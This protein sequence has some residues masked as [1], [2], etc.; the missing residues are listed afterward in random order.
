[1]KPN[2][3]GVWEWFDENGTKRLMD[4]VDVGTAEHPWFRVYWWGGYYDVYDNPEEPEKSPFR[5]AEW[6]D[7]WGKFVGEEGSVEE[8]KLYHMPD[9]KKLQKIHKLRR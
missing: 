3:P 2:K 1:M 7:R 5:Y 4:V 6:P 8:E 9:R